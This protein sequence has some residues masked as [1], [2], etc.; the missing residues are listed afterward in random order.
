MIF[1]NSFDHWAYVVISCFFLERLQLGIGKIRGEFAGAKKIQN[2]FE[3][4]ARSVNKMIAFFV[5]LNLSS[6]MVSKQIRLYAWNKNSPYIS[7]RTWL[8]ASNL[9]QCKGSWKW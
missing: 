3:Q 1:L 5:W 4:V 9:D 8:L 7:Q 6:K 2:N